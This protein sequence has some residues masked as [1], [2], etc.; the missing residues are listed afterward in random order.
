[1]K[2]IVN[3]IQHMYYTLQLCTLLYILTALNK[4]IPHLAASFCCP[5][6]LLKH[7]YFLF[8]GNLSSGYNSQTIPA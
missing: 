4:N 2:I 6:P 8:K 1:M 5:N 7:R 3:R